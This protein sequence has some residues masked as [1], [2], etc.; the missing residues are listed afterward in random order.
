MASYY[1]ADGKSEVKTW[2][3]FQKETCFSFEAKNNSTLL[4]VN[5]HG[6]AIHKHASSQHLRT[7]DPVYHDA[8]RFITKS[9]AS[10]HHCD[11][12]YWQTR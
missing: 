7:S 12:S 11:W 9:T 8:L 5:D 3:L 4:L 10:T 6:D 2:L 1:A